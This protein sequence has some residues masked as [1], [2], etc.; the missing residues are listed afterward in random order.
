MDTQ[1][2]AAPAAEQ[3]E[4]MDTKADAPAAAAT[5]S[6]PVQE[7]TPEEQAFDVISSL[8]AEQQ[9][10]TLIDS[11]LPIFVIFCTAWHCIRF[12]LLTLTVASRHCLC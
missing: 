11:L 8:P 1:P 4:A 9:A 3:T 12:E 7:K 10:S 6:E 2:E 5:E